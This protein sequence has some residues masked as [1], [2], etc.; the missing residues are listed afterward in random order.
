MYNEKI[1]MTQKTHI[2]SQEQENDKRS[3]SGG[4]K[5]KFGY[6]AIAYFFSVAAFYDA[7]GLVLLFFGLDDFWIGDTLYGFLFTAPFLFYCHHKRI[8][9]ANWAVFGLLF[10]LVPYLSIL[11]LHSVYFLF[12]V[13]TTNAKSASLVQIAGKMKKHA[14]V[15]KGQ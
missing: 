15:L 1:F 12:K 6:F 13:W 8:R 2:Q 9:A 10:E 14:P 5:G 11:L 4:K 3:Q 7:V